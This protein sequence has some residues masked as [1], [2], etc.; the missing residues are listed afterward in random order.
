MDQPRHVRRVGHDL[1][2]ALAQF[3]QRALRAVAFDQ[4]AFEHRP[5]HRPDVQLRVELAAD[6]FDV[7]QCLLQQDQLR[8]QGQLVALGHAEQLDQYLG[9]RDLRQRPGEVRLAHRARRRLQL[10]DA[11]VGRHPARLHVQ[12]GHA[13]VVLVEDGHEVLGQVVLIFLRELAHDA[14]VQRDEAR[15]VAARRV[16][17]DP[18]VAG[19]RIGMEEVVAEHLGVEHP[20]ALGRQRAA[21][22][23]GGVQRGDVV[24]GDAA[25][26]LQGQRA[27]GGVGP[28]HLR[29][30]EVVRVQPETAQHAGVG[31]LALQVQLRGEGGLDLGHHLARADLVGAR[32]GALDQRGGRF[33]QGDVGVDLPL[34]VRAQHLDHHFAAVVQRRR[35]HL[36]DRGRGQRFGVEGRE[37]HRDRPP[38][39]LFHD[40]PRRLAV[41]RAHPVLQQGQF[42]GHVRRHQVTPGGEDLPELDEDR[43]QVLQRQA[44][45]GAARLRSDVGAGARHERLGQAQPALGRGAVEQVVQAIAQDHPADAAGA[46][47]RLHAPRSGCSRA[48][49]AA[50]RSMSSRSTSTSS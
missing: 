35:V 8:L 11:H 3:L 33:Q 14:E 50:R 21:V 30:V 47:H 25:H 28:D 45:P 1:R 40:A 20:H 37:R 16:A 18:D 36:R 13:P 12:L 9:Q 32:M 31:A 19:V 46:E 4:D 2:Q 41:E 44:Q 17:V 10:V 6:A 15:V 38:Q 39:R 42:L 23:A 22:D 7:E 5:R 34:D 48:T 29:H 43:P 49:R 24:G 27:L 26:P